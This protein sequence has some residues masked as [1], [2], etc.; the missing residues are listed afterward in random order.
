MPRKPRISL[1]P[2]P[3]AF[4]IFLIDF[5]FSHVREEAHPICTLC[6]TCTREPWIEVSIS[7]PSSPG[8]D[9]L[10]IF[11]RCSSAAREHPIPIERTCLCLRRLCHKNM[12]VLAY[13]YLF[14][15][16]LSCFEKKKNGLENTRDEKN[17][18]LLFFFYK[19][20]CVTVRCR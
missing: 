20:K 16:K 1:P 2:P 11:E 18:A 12:R 14:K 4:E 15:K 10:P 3:S 8:T 13:L 19:Y 6:R 5:S 17:V 9:L 7:R